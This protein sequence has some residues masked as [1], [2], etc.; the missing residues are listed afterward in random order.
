MV[1]LIEILQT[2]VL[3]LGGIA[4]A[5]IAHGLFTSTTGNGHLVIPF[6]CGLSLLGW[7]GLDG[8][9]RLYAVLSTIAMVVG[10]WIWGLP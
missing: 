1:S 9:M 8:N 7:I 5:A 6:L 3:F 2:L 10:M 4:M